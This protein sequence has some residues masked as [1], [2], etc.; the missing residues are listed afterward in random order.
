MTVI[1][2]LKLEKFKG[3]SQGEINLAPL[4]III[5]ANNSGKTTILEALFLAPNPFREV[6]YLVE[7]ND[8]AIRIIGALHKTLESEGYLFLLHNYTSKIARVECE[9]DESP[10]LLELI[11]AFN[12][13]YVSTNREIGD[14]VSIDGKE[15][16]IIGRLDAQSSSRMDIKIEKPLID[17]TLLLSSSLTKYAYEYLRM[18]WASIVNLGICRG[19]A[20]EASTFSNERYVDLTMEPFIG[21]T[22]SINAYRH[23]GARRRLG[24]LG[25]GVQGYIISRILYE[26]AQPKVLLWD[27]VEAH[28][29][30]RILLSISG[31]ISELVEKGRQVVLTTHSL[32]AVR[33]IAGESQDKA[34]IYLISLVDGTLNTRE[35]TLQEVEELIEAGVDVR[36]AEPLL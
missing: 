8:R 23:D 36:A 15:K 30:P 11:R 2:R 17:D 25:D 7:G 26:I 19:A 29:N 35:L 3:V 28:F 12:F 34:R 20:E 18:N 9:T 22:L 21:G 14:R 10:Y 27:D 6:P 4:T 33:M 16:R 31:W 13:I 32:E 1:R 5:G 24:D